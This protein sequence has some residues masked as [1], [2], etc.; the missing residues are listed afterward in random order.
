MYPL[1]FE[2]IY[3]EKIWGGDALE[4]LFDRKLP[5]RRVGES[6]EIAAHSHG[7]SVV[8][9]GPL[10]GTKLADLIQNR[11]REIM[12]DTPLGDDGQ[13]PLLVKLLDCNDWLSV[14][15]HPDDD[16]ARQYAQ[17]ELGKTETWI[18]L[19]TQPGAKIVYGTKPGT[20]REQFAEAIAKGTV[21]ELLQLVEVQV[22]EVY[23][24]PAGTLHALGRGVVVA[25]IQQNSDT[26]YRVYDWNRLG[27]DG[28]PRELHVKQALEVIDFQ[29]V[30]PAPEERVKGD[31]AL[32]ETTSQYQRSLLDA[33]DKYVIEGIELKGQWRVE[34][35][36]RM[37]IFV[38][39]DGQ[40]T[41]SGGG[42]E[43]KLRSGTSVLVP[44]AV[45]DL[46]IEGAGLWLR[47]FVPTQE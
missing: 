16:Y 4:A 32:I 7:Q 22:G 23:S 33:N 1:L 3:K 20:T 41:M 6:W 31:S 9:N 36:N 15:V 43:V 44:A 46:T 30:V 10:A 19:A 45:K 42:E 17:G 25:E 38:L 5:S 40:C 14:Q 34:P 39:I 29:Q 11:R 2:P 37:E 21:E 28:Q 24:V 8:S 26:V 27:D 13:F 18:V 12:G 47:T 35:E